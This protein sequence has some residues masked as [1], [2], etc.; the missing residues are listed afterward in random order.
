MG[1]MSAS[2][3]SFIERRFPGQEAEWVK[4]YKEV[5]LLCHFFYHYFTRV[6]PKFSGLPT[7]R[8]CF[9]LQEGPAT[10]EDLEQW[11]R[12]SG[13]IGQR[14]GPYGWVQVRADWK[15]DDWV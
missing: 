5:S 1:H 10:A 4:I 15:Y 12:Y 11:A 6:N 14:P 13:W 9:A 2:I 7:P 8:N 3:N